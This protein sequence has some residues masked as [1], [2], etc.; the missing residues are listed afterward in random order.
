MKEFMKSLGVLILEIAIILSYGF[1]L[2]KLWVWFIVPVF[3]LPVLTI[4]YAIGLMLV[5][6]LVR[7][8]FPAI[9]MDMFEEE[10]RNKIL[11]AF[12]VANLYSLGQLS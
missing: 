12:R 7:P 10:K 1:A 3:A 4:A 5:V 2:T 9:S 6:N 8:V 11:A